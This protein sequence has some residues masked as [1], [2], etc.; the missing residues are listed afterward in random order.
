MPTPNSLTSISN[1]VQ[2]YFEGMH[3]GDASRLRD[4]F[5]ADAFL[6]GHYQGAFTRQSLDEWISEV[7]GLPKPHEQGEPF[8]MKIIA[9]DVTGRAASVKVAVL[10]M[11]LR[12]TD[13]LTLMEIGD[14]WKVMHKAYHHD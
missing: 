1:T 7:D 8:D 2:R 4:A 10:Y 3:F 6:V 5:H 12:F 14:G 9:T 11:G 13:Y